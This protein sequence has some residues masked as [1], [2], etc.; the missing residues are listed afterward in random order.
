MPSRSARTLRGATFRFVLKSDLRFVQNTHDP[1]QRN[2]ED[3]ILAARPVAFT[4][5]KKGASDRGAFS[6][7]RRRLTS[8]TRRFPSSPDC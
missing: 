6:V 3:N 8:E 1:D 7:L 5:H 4:G 2:V